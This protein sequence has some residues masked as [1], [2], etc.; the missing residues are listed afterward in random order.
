MKMLSLLREKNLSSL[1]SNL[2]V[3]AVGLASFMLLARQLDRAS[4]GDWVLYLA[5]VSFADLL[6]F[7][8][9]RTAAV[10]MLSDAD[11]AKT[12]AVMGSSFWLN[13]LLTGLVMLICWPMAAL[14]Y[15][16]EVPV[17]AGY[18]LFLQWYPL[19]ALVNMGW[20]N[21]MS[22]FQARQSF[23]RMMYVRLSNSGLFL[24]FLIFNGLYFHLG[25]LPI[26]LVHLSG[27]LLSSIWTGIRRW[28]GMAHLGHAT[29]AMRGELVNFGKFAM[30]TLVGASLLRSADTFI[31]GLSAALGSEAVALYAIPLKLTDLLGIPLHSFTMTAYPR[32]AQ[33]Y[34]KGDIA[35]LRH[36]FYT[37]TGAV[38]LLFIPIAVLCFIFAEPLVLLLGGSEYE[39][40]LHQVAGLFRIFTVYTLLLPADRFSGVALDSINRPDIN[41]RKV[42]IMTAA[43]ISIDLVAVFVFQ[44]L[45]MV[46]VGTVI[47]TLIGIWIGM[48]ALH[49]NIA[50]SILQIPK[51]GLGFFKALPGYLRQ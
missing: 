16:T 10:R 22:L 15:W 41:L 43:N 42:M 20:N 44:S 28:D 26:L 24:L 3:A 17:S 2:S 19:L 5:L 14:L 27:H 35:G 48:R 40:A 18:S 36:F 34:L 4:F 37:Y 50:I 9:T 29:K 13:L 51:R 23:W 39:T 49:Q 1:I 7:G 25:L 30:G 31:I 11:D 33:R 45:E 46:A 6:R 12:R 8:L 21:A 47:F 38:S 32:M